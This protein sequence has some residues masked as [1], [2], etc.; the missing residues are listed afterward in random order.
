MKRWKSF[1]RKTSLKAQTFIGER[2]RQLMREGYPRKQAI[3]IAHSEARKKGYKIKH[4]E[5]TESE[6]RYYPSL[7][8]EHYGGA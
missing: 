6:K 2:I 5:P 7:D 8:V 1:N 4:Y 3:A